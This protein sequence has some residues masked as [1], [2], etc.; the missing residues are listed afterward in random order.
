MISTARILGALVKR[1][2]RAGRFRNPGKHGM[3]LTPVTGSHR[4]AKIRPTTEPH[5]E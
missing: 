5:P 2:R 3:V 4:C 1:A